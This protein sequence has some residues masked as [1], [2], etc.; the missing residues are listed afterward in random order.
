MTT[1]HG[2]G[3]IDYVSRY[4]AAAAGIDEDPVTSSIN[5]SLAAH[6]AKQLGKT[7]LR[8]QQLSTRGEIMQCTLVGDRV[9]ISGTALLYMLGAIKLNI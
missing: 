6:W 9:R 7:S 2:T 3:N 4:F 1:T 5:C 8:V